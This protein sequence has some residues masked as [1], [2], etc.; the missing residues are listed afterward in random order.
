MI[1]SEITEFVKKALHLV[2]IN[3]PYI[4]ELT[5]NI[6]LVATDKIDTAGI[7]ASGR[8]IYNPDWL[9]K[10]SLTDVAFIIA[11]EIMHLALNTH[12]RASIIDKELFNITHD[13]IINELLKET[14]NLRKTPA[15]GLDWSKEYK[16][17]Y[18][19]KNKSAEELMKFIKDALEKGQ[20]NK[21]IFR[22]H[23]GGD[24]IWVTPEIN[25]TLAEKLKELFPY[26]NTD[27][28][29]N[30]T[31]LIQHETDVLNEELEK[32]IFPATSN[33]QITEKKEKI[34]QQVG[35]ALSTKLMIEKA[36][37][38]FKTIKGTNAGRA[39]NIYKAIQ[40]LYQP[41]WEIA[42]QKWVE[43]TQRSGKTYSRPSRRGQ[44]KNFVRPG[45]KREG[46]TLHIV[47]DTSG[48][49]SRILG[50]V[51]GVI[52]SFCETLQIPEIHI[53]QCDTQVSD[54]NWYSP[55]ELL[56]FQINGLGGSDMSP[57]MLRLSSDN[58][59]E[60]VLVITDGYINYPQNPMPYEVLWVLTGNNDYFKPNYGTVIQIDK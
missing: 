43:N 18:E 16:N 56:S 1:D 36:D 33:K 17:Y 23:W 7:F 45:Y 54:D 55:S 42:L 2:R 31:V 20:L 29:K 13:F 60:Y 5:H 50:K 51:L 35:K 19:I 47:I 59:V 8:L 49:M 52:S 28:R 4:A 58:E 48:S 9:E 6:E 34:K 24:L 38:Y 30:Q 27:N 37:D 40:A 12:Q 26:Q 14:F 3:I 44:Y 21:R 22:K 57:G 46:K 11:H 15:N 41:P 10:M 32:I 53:I 25:N 39:S